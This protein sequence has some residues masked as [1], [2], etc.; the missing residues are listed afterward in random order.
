MEFPTVY[1]YVNKSGL[2]EV[3][4]I[5][6]CKEKYDWGFECRILQE[7]CGGKRILGLLREVCILCCCRECMCEVKQDDTIIFSVVKPTFT[8]Y[9]MPVT[10]SFIPGDSKSRYKPHAVKMWLVVWDILSSSGHFIHWHLTLVSL[11]QLQSWSTL[12]GNKRWQTW[13]L[14]WNAV[15]LQASAKRL[16]FLTHI[17]FCV[18]FFHTGWKMVLSKYTWLEWKCTVSKWIREVLCHKTIRRRREVISQTA[19]HE[20][21]LVLSHRQAVSESRSRDRMVWMMHSFT[22]SQGALQYEVAE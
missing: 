19:G 9:K 13:K 4:D 21:K 16:T 2:F 8:S 14:A 5:L 6:P 22:T 20:Q 12:T 1:T 11:T 10:A 15:Q 18:Q 7:V 17:C 3:L